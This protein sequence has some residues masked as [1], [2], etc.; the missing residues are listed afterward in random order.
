MFE[1]GLLKNKPIRSFLKERETLISRKKLVDIL[2]I[3]PLMGQ[4]LPPGIRPEDAIEVV[5][6]SAWARGLAEGVCLTGDTL[7]YTNP[8][9]SEISENVDVALGEDGVYHQVLR[10]YERNYSGD[11]VELHP[12]NN[13]K[14]LL[15]PEHPIAFR[16]G[17]KLRC[18]KAKYIKAGDFLI[19]PKLIEVSDVEFIDLPHA[20]ENRKYKKVMDMHSLGAPP[21]QIAHCLKLKHQTVDG[22][23]SGRYKPKFIDVPES[24][25]TSEDA[26]EFLGLYVA[27]GFTTGSKVNFAL[28]TQEQDLANLVSRL[29]KELFNRET[30]T[31]YW[32][33]TKSSCVVFSCLPLAKFLRTNFYIGGFRAANKILPSW[34]MHLPPIKQASF[35]RGLW[36]GDGSIG[37]KT[38]EFSTAS[39][40]LAMQ[41]RMIL[42]RLN[43]L[44][45]IKRKHPKPYVYGDRIVNTNGPKYI[46]RVTALEQL[47]NMASILKLSKPPYCNNVKKH[48]RPNFRNMGSH[49]EVPVLS[50]QKVPFNGKVYNLAVNGG[51]YTANGVLVHNCGPG[52]AGFTPG[53]PEFDHCVWNVSHKVAARVLG[54]TWVAPAP[55]PPRPR[56][57]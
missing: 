42:M 47:E 12:Q 37:E 7:V 48:R 34:L 35:L 1:E 33:G 5:A 49:F 14:L 22:W 52:Y 44:P 38:Y 50:V 32:K 45:S 43:L 31:R 55:P 57:R 19:L 51:W 6:R 53:T 10:T 18:G 20:E 54:L 41:I 11:L 30:W 17:R 27:E 25:P 9:V 4:E 56:R 26:L 46:L 3:N 39:V 15:T 29:A 36:L 28:S 21:S 8:S 16:R 13:L 2:E 40:K 23:L 24:I